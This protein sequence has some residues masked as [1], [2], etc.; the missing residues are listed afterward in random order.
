MVEDEL[1]TILK[2]H[3][4]KYPGWDYAI[5]RDRCNLTEPFEVVTGTTSSGLR[6]VLEIVAGFMLSRW[7]DARFSSDILVSGDT[8]VLPPGEGQPGLS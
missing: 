4:A 3:L 6:Y 2:Q 7:D 5:F 1:Q 8:T